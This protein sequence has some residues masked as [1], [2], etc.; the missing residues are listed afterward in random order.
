[1]G[2]WQSR[3]VF[4]LRK[5]LNL[6]LPVSIKSFSCGLVS[7]VSQS[8]DPLKILPGVEH[9]MCGILGFFSWSFFWDFSSSFP[10]AHGSLGCYSF[11]SRPNG[12][13]E[14]KRC[15]VLV[16]HLKNQ[17]G[18]QKR[19]GK[20]DVC[21]SEGVK[22]RAGQLEWDG[23]GMLRYKKKPIPTNWLWLKAPHIGFSLPLTWTK[24][25]FSLCV[26]SAVGEMDWTQKQLPRMMRV[27]L[28]N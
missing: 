15:W 17:N 23:E 28:E 27:N 21:V 14:G 8:Q 12:M 6:L 26:S 20:N 10:S 25:R 22:E 3:A 1:M 5:P 18:R 9:E 19:T 2:L 24:V 13:E 7:R 11:F 16:K 4:L